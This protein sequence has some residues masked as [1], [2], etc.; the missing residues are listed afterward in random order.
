MGEIRRVEERLIPY[1]L[2]REGHG[3]LLGLAPDEKTSSMNLFDDV[4]IGTLVLAKT[5]R[6]RR[7]IL[8]MRL[9]RGVE[10]LETKQQPGNAALEKSDLDPWELIEDAVVD[11]ARAV[12]RL[13]PRVTEGVNGHEHVQMIKTK[14]VV[15]SAVYREHTSKAFGL[16]IDWPVGL[17]PKEMWQS[18]R[19]HHRAE[20]AKLG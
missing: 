19:R 12:D 5:V 3:Q 1:N 6:S 9:V 11:D 17:C 4:A 16:C 2:D 15:R 20:H 13:T 7:E 10:P 18:I 8:K 14:V